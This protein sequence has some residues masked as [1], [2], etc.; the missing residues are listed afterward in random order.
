MII[1]S[2]LN[3][4]MNIYSPGPTV[5]VTY[6]VTLRYPLEQKAILASDILV[7]AYKKKITGEYE[8]EHL[9]ASKLASELRLISLC[10]FSF[11]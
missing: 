3:K 2:W 1:L 5:N 10:F 8:E 4:R 11:S 9:D 6:C 7:L